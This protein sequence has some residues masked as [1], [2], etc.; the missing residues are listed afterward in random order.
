[1]LKITDKD[2][3]NKEMCIATSEERKEGCKAE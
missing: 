3:T 2:L 1:M